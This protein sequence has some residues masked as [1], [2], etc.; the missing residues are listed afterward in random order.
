MAL[1]AL[2]YEGLP[3]CEEARNGAI[4]YDGSAYRFKEWKFRTEVEIEVARQGESAR[5]RVKKTTEIVRA[6]RKEA[7]DIAQDIEREL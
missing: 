1:S 2:K 7:A 5:D 4:I 3:K 6:L